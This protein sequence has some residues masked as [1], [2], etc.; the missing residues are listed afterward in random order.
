MDLINLIKNFNRPHLFTTPSHCGVGFGEFAKVVGQRIF[1]CDFSEIDGFDNIR[2]P[3]S[4]FKSSLAKASLIYDSGASFYLYNG[5]TA[6]ILALMLSVLDIDTQVLIPRNCHISVLNGLILTHAQG[7]FLEPEYDDVFGVAKA[8]EPSAVEQK[9]TEHPDIKAVIVT[10]PTY[11]GVVSDIEAIAQICHERGVVLVVDEA[12]GALWNFS[13]RLPTPSIHL[14]AD[15]TVQSLHK[16][17]GALTQSSILHISKNSLIT[18]GKVQESLNLINSTSPSYLLLASIE[19]AI[20]YLHS[21]KG[22]LKLEKLLD[23]IIHIRKELSQI[24]GVSLF[25]NDDF[26]KIFVKVEGLS[27]EKLSDLLYKNKIEDELINESGVLLLCGLGTTHRK[28]K[29][30]C[31]VVKKIATT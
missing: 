29:K 26:T 25:E 4:I 22:S 10:S 6:G 3:K 15:A 30:L 28:L 5:S 18:P 8:I 16:T 21:R 19:G 27:G 20:K 11:E 12:H 31:K 1:R 23:E 24:D 2:N 14:G 7:V 17:A 13:D 9:L